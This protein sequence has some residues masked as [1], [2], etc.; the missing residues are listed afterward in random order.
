[1]FHVDAFTNKPFAGNPAGVC[2]LSAP[3]DERWMQAVAAEMNLPATG[4]LCRHEDGF[5]LRW[6]TPTV[7]DDMCGHATLASAHILWEVGWLGRAERAQFYT[8][9]GV[10][11]AKCRADWIELDFPALS[12]EP[13]TISQAYTDALGITP[14]YVGR[15]G[16]KH[17]LEVGTEDAVRGLKPD[18]AAPRRLPGRGIVVTSR[19]APA[20]YDFVSRYF[21]P[22]MGVD[23][24]PVTGSNHCGLGPF[25]GK[26]LGK[27]ELKAYQASARGGEIR[28]RLGDERVYLSGQAVTISKGELLI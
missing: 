11:R 6:F 25:W 1:M 9:G 3:G 22:W 4:F 14:I 19:A 10:L 15:I 20:G 17:L 2:L 28:I 24:D 27:K 16:A 23:E 21:A 8:R 13:A 26:R 5:R 12:E 18:F 7:E